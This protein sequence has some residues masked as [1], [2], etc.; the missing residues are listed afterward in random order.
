VKNS[1]PTGILGKMPRFGIGYDFISCHS[2][3]R[4]IA[5]RLSLFKAYQINNTKSPRGITRSSGQNP[6]AN[7]KGQDHQGK[8]K[9]KHE[10]TPLSNWFPHHHGVKPAANATEF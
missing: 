1:V 4:S 10:N 6:A 9:P 7:I 8:S 2:C 3:D 5:L